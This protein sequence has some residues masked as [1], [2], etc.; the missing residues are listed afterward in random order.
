MGQSLSLFQNEFA[1]M[2]AQCHI[3]LSAED[4]ATA[5][6]VF[7]AMTAEVRRLDAKYSLFREDSLLNEINRRAG[8]GEVLELDDETANLIDHAEVAHEL[9][10]GRFDITAGPLTRLWD[11]EYR[12]LP[13]LQDI[14]KARRRVGWEHLNWQRPMLELRRPDMQLEFG[15][16]VKEYASDAAAEVARVLGI[17]HGFVRLGGDVSVIGP[18]PDGADWQISIP[19]PFHPHQVMTDIRIGDGGLASSGDYDRCQIIDGRRYGHIVNPNTGWPVQSFASISILGPSCMVA[20]TL[21][22]IGMLLGVE[23]APTWLANIAMPY[24]AVSWDGQVSGSLSRRART[25]APLH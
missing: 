6:I 11:S 3:C 23:D 22:T 7:E 12:H 1:A 13:R 14:D 5:N 9:S 15:G 24:L 21:S 25:P 19:D 17:Q 2:G 4:E 8:K 16:L 10:A 20:G 18:R